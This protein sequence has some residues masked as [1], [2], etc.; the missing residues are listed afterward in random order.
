MRKV[1]VSG[2]L[3]MGPS[4]FNDIAGRTELLRSTGRTA[5]PHR[6]AFGRHLA[7]RGLISL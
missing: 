2:A 6:F 7:T 4:I 1:N 3:W 5:N